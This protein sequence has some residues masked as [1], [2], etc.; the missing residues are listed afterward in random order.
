MRIVS[1][2]QY[3]QFYASQYGIKTTV[4]ENGKIFPAYEKHYSGWKRAGIIAKAFFESLPLFTLLFKN[5]QEDLF[6]AIYGKKILVIQDDSLKDLGTKTL[7]IK[8]SPE[9]NASNTSDD[10]LEKETNQIRNQLLSAYMGYTE[11]T[12]E[13]L[14]TSILENIHKL[15]KEELEAVNLTLSELI[16]DIKELKQTIERDA[17][18]EMTATTDK[19]TISYDQGLIEISFQE[20]AF[21][22]ESTEDGSTKWRKIEGFP[23]LQCAYE[24]LSQEFPDAVKWKDSEPSHILILAKDTFD[25]VKKARTDRI[26][27]QFLSDYKDCAKKIGGSLNESHIEGIKKL[28]DI[29]VNYIDHILLHLTKDIKE[30]QIKKV[31][32]KLESGQVLKNSRYII[33]YVPH[34]NGKTGVFEIVLTNEISHYKIKYSEKTKRIQSFPFLECAYEKLYKNLIPNVAVRPFEEKYQFQRMYNFCI[35]VLS[36]D[37]SF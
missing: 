2:Q 29:D 32:G 12:K 19:Y 31:E 28:D 18:S 27:N 13:P 25:K 21:A 1:K 35:E 6:A 37:T 4:K 33:D 9:K 36:T 30:L 14:D 20:K 11:R 26:R 15:K 23:L 16:K 3:D 5:V 17:S 24:R 7:Q 22:Y 34:E 8:T 10:K